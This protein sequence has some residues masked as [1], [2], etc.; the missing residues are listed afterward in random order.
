MSKDIMVTYLSK[1]VNQIIH[2]KL[3]VDVTKQVGLI[4]ISE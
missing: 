3:L 2:L 1:R 4:P